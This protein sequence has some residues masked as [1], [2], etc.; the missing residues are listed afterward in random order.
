MSLPAFTVGNANT[1]EISLDGVKLDISPLIRD[2]VARFTLSGDGKPTAANP[3]PTP[4]LP[5]E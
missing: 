2:E 1:A 3:V 5:N 4:T